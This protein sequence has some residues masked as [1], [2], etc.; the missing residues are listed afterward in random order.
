[1]TVDPRTLTDNELIR[2]ADNIINATKQSL[3]AA[4]Q[5]EFV[6]RLDKQQSANLAE[7]SAHD[8]S[9]QLRLFP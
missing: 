7:I 1:M 9:K 4:W 3:N 8:D 5:R 2:I 6:D